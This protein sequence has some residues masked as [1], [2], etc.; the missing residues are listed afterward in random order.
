MELK[1]RGER[2]MPK[3]LRLVAAL[4]AALFVLSFL[5]CAAFMAVHTEH[6]C[7]G[8]GCAVCALLGLC[9]RV[10]R[11]LFPLLAAAVTLA[12]P[13]KGRA[14]AAGAPGVRDRMTPVLLRV[15]LTD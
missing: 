10:L 7:C 15:K 6:N 12:A 5:L 11:G 14:A 2:H 1:E 13:R 3:K 9:E 8:E 4:F